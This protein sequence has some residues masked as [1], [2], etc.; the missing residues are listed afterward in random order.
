MAL[1]IPDYT[2]TSR[3]YTPGIIP[4]TTF[5]GQNGATT[6]IRFGNIPI[7]VKLQ[8]TYQNVDEAVAY[9]FIQF[10]NKCIMEDEDVRIFDRKNSTKDIKDN[11]FSSLV[12]GRKDSLKWRF[13]KPI[14]VQF[15]L[16]SR[17]NVNIDLIGVLIA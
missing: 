17:Y 5:Q 8:M 11:D 15:A 14:V 3:V 7:D 9:E 10:Y 1:N 16:A 6:Y 13:A 12:A 4:E 2:P